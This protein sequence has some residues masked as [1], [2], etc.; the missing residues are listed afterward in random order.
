MTK[1][2]IRWKRWLCRPFPWHSQDPILVPCPLPP[3][4][5]L[6]PSLT[7]WKH[8]T[9]VQHSHEVVDITVNALGHTGVLQRGKGSYLGRQQARLS[10]ST[11]FSAMSDR[12]RPLAWMKQ[13]CHDLTHH[14]PALHFSTPYPQEKPLAPA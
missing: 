1:R 7:F 13:G 4:S 9:H 14:H 8:V 3:T 2:A 10:P 6:Q 12:I 5:G 11:N